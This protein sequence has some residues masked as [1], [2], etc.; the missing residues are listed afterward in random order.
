MEQNSSVDQA[1]LDA[2]FLER[3]G[4]EIRRFIIAVIAMLIGLLISGFAEQIAAFLNA[5]ENVDLSEGAISTFGLVINLCG[6]G[7]LA[8]WILDGK[9]YVF[10]RKKVQLEGIT[11][12]PAK[13][14]QEREA[15]WRAQL[16]R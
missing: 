9:N 16:K 7:T 5:S 11:E 1:Y 14:E 10:P 12:E 15:N 4:K 3:R 6:F 8:M 2:Y 13:S